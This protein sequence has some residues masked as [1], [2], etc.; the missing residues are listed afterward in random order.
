MYNFI[1]TFVLSTTLVAYPVLLYA[2]RVDRGFYYHMVPLP[3]MVW[4]PLF[5]AIVATAWYCDFKTRGSFKLLA[6]GAANVAYV[7]LTL[8][9]S[10]GL[11][12]IIHRSD[13]GALKKFLVYQFSPWLL[14]VAAIAN[15][16][17]LALCFNERRRGPQPK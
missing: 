4:W 11:I 12:I 10:S 7:L 14:L 15:L 1:K 2:F 5:F 9:F 8:G 16:A 3:T 6:T 17:L 13:P